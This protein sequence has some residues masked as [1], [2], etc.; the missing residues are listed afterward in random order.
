MAPTAVSRDDRDFWKLMLRN[1]RGRELRALDFIA[2]PGRKY[3]V[4]EVLVVEVL[5]RWCPGMVWQVTPVSGDAGVDFTGERES[6]RLSVF[7]NI[8]LRWKVAGQVKR[9]RSP[10]EEVLM[11]ALASVRKL[12]RREPIAGAMFVI[13]AAT[14]REIVDRLF[15]KESLWHE[16]NGPRW[17]VPAEHFLACLAADLERLATITSDCYSAAEQGIIQKH[18][19]RVPPS[20]G[21]SLASSAKIP[22]FGDAGRAIRCV[23]SL[24]STTPMPQECLVLRHRSAT[25]E[26]NPIEIA[27]PSRMAAPGGLTIFLRGPDEYRLDVWLRCFVPGRRNLGG[28]DIFDP[29]GRSVGS[30]EL[31]EIEVRP[32]LAPPYYSTPNLALERDMMRRV[33]EAADRSFDAV[34]VIGAGGAG[35]SRFCERSIDMAVDEGFDWIS[36]GHENTPAS[37]RRLLLNLLATLATTAAEQMAVTEDT[38]LA[39]ERVVGRQRPHVV[40]ALSRYVHHED[41]PPDHDHVAT[42]LLAL[43]ADRTRDR[44]LAIH[45]YDLH[46]AGSE[47]FAVLALLVEYLRRNQGSLECG[48]LLLLEGRSRESLLLEEDKT[49]RI[50]TEWLR[51]LQASGIEKAEIRPWSPEECGEYLAQTI[52]ASVDLAHPLDPSV[53]PLHR[54]LLNHIRDRAQG[55]PMHLMEQ[56]KRLHELGIIAQHENGLLY[57]RNALPSVFDTPPRVEDLIRA[58]IN[59]HRHLDPASIDFLIVL[60]LIGRRIPSNLFTALVRRLRCGDRL[61]LIARMDVAVLPRDEASSFFFAHENYLRVFRSCD[62]SPTSEALLVAI[63]HYDGLEVPSPQQKSEQ[64]RLLMAAGGHPRTKVLE[65]TTDGIDESRRDEDDQLLEVFLRGFLALEGDLQQRAGVDPLDIRYELAEIMTRTG[66]WGDARTELEWIVDLASGYTGTKKAYQL[67]RAKA[68]LANVYVSQQEPDAAVEATDE[69]LRIVESELLTESGDRF[70]LLPLQEK[71]WHRRAVA[72]WFDG[73]AVEAVQWQWRAYRSIMRRGDRY[74]LTTILRELGTILLHRNPA[75]GSRLLERALSVGQSLPRLHHEALFIIEAQLAMGR[76]LQATDE[77][78]PDSTVATILDDAIIIHHK[79]LRQL[80]RYEAAISALVCGAA[81]GFLRSIE[82]AHGWFRTAVEIAVQAGLEDENWKARLNLAQ[83]ASEME[84]PSEAKLNAAEAHRILV[85]GLSSGSVERRR[86]RRELMKLPLA[87]VVRLQ[88]SDAM[89]AALHA[90]SSAQIAP[91]DWEKRPRFRD[92]TSQQVLHVRR[93]QFDY[94]LMN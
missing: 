80:T 53:L 65:L 10:K 91:G 60:A 63:E 16:F 92:R 23:I 44:A 18:L 77:G 38:L 35:K 72:M 22:E 11:R 50:P 83:I 29:A 2:H 26:A 54:E 82:D 4:F 9:M 21:S 87:H 42:A 14:S 79:C 73:R 34:A 71:L 93:D 70:R 5:R 20:F 62:L 1:V 6:V 3:Q 85:K 52:L 74:E 30:V 61:P 7:G 25:C 13:S 32:F 27:R 47:L 64:I 57:V 8:E 41:H 56:L 43:I 69:G 86:H 89:A 33:E 78:A 90:M 28:V 31:G 48:V 45:L 36:L 49:F 81:S 75:F 58:R 17:Y 84:R 68:E 39:V 24:R 66:T 37:G 40:E 19:Q 94:F 76:L 51:Y 67:A 88:G 55:N 12:A 59:Y 46:W 15:A